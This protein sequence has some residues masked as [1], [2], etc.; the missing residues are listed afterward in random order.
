MFEQD[1][2]LSK[3]HRL[4]N[5]ACCLARLARC[6]EARP[7]LAQAKEQFAALAPRVT[8]CAEYVAMCTALDEALARGQPETVLGPWTEWSRE[9]LTKE[10][11]SAPR[12]RRSK[13]AP[14]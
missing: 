3:D 11:P 12:A 9:K 10:L 14:T 13:A 5:R 8:W 7:F 1:E 2:I 4:F 6:D